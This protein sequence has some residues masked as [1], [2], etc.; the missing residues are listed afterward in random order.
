MTKKDPIPGVLSLYQ[1]LLSQL[2]WVS[3]PS[4]SEA[5]GFIPFVKEDEAV[6]GHRSSP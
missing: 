3:S 1:E 4:A 6:L 5:G 2:W